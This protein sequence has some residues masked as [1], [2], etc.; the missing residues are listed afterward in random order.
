MARSHGQ[1]RA[2]HVNSLYKLLVPRMK[3]GGGKN[4]T[5]LLEYLLRGISFV[6]NIL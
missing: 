6:A 3:A 5:I 4:G 2:I 1:I